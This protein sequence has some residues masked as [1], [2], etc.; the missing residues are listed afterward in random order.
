MQDSHSVK[1]R[2]EEL[3]LSVNEVASMS[4]ISPGTIYR[5]E[6]SATNPYKVNVETARALAK[7]LDA[8]L[9]SLF[10]G[11]E[12]SELGRTPKTGVETGRNAHHRENDVCSHCNIIIPLA[13]PTCPECAPLHTA[14]VAV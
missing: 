11:D 1:R 9:L 13:Y 5:I 7:A 3:S 4:G 6:H 10:R 8:P 2:R 12:L 14:A